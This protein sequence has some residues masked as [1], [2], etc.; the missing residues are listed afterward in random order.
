MCINYMADER[1]KNKN[2]LLNI[3][4]FPNSASFRMGV[5]GSLYL[6]TGFKL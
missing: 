1:Y 3:Q 5:G 6:L 4:K 2:K